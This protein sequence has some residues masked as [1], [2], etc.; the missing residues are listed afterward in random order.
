MFVLHFTEILQNNVLDQATLDRVSCFRM[1]T[2]DVT[3]HQVEQFGE[4][5]QIVHLRSPCC[6]C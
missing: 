6:C 5:V 1:E 4:Y 2:L 3:H